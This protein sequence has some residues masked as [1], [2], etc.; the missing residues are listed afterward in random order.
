MDALT[1]LEIAA[2]RLHPALIGANSTR[3]AE[4]LQLNGL[5]VV[6]FAIFEDFLR[7]R[8]L[9]ILEALGKSKVKFDSF[10]DEFKL[11]ILQETYKGI[12]FF[13]SK[14]VA[15]KTD[16]LLIEAMNLNTAADQKLDF[17]PSQFAFG[18]SQSNVSLA[19]ITAFL[20]SFGMSSIECLREIQRRIGFAH[21][22][23]PEGIFSR[24]A[25]NRHSAAHAFNVNF[26]IVEFADDVKAAFKVLAFAFDTTLSQRAHALKVA[27]LKNETL[28]FFGPDS[29]VF[30]SFR[31]DTIKKQ[32]RV[33]I[34]KHDGETEQSPVKENSLSAKLSTLLNSTKKLEETV[35]VIDRNGTLTTWLQPI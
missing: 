14:K 34:E 30:K 22:G 26:N 23:G 13:L 8:T 35:Y 24:M 5:H 17:V 21:L 16:T 2:S 11:Q 4:Y 31:F 9:E 18:R 28:G 33:A 25:E 20:D 7:R 10:P 19:Q 3:S 27:T 15:D 12:N 1:Q 32:W 29:V 6:T